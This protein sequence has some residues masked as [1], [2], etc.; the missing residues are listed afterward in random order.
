MMIHTL[1]SHCWKK[2]AQWFYE[3]KRSNEIYVAEIPL[4]RQC[5]REFEGD[6]TWT[7]GW[8][9]DCG[10][11]GKTGQED[12]TNHTTGWASQ[13]QGERGS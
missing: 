3:G 1:Y 12:F 6:E 2:K 8:L 9:G 5:S 11:L 10:R 4:W 7:D 13:C